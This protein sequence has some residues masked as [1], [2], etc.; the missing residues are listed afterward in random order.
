ARGVTHVA[1]ITPDDFLLDYLRVVR[2]EAPADDLKETFGYKL[3]TGSPAPRWLRPIPFRARF[4]SPQG[5][6]LLFEVVPPQTDFDCAWNRAVAEVADG[7]SSMADAD[8]RQAI[9]LT[10]PDRRASL[11]E[12]AGAT[13]YRWGDHRVAIT[14]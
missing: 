4:P 2:P 9:A 7:R 12:T 5:R 14:M 13:A 10:N 6:A 8:F 11:F 1:M 3:M